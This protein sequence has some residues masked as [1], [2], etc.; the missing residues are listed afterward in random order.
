M[1]FICCSTCSNN[2]KQCSGLQDSHEPTYRQSLPAEFKNILFQVKY[3]CPYCILSKCGFDLPK[4]NLDGKQFFESESQMDEADDLYLIEVQSLIE[5]IGDDDQTL[6]S[7]DA[8]F[9]TPPELRR[10][11]MLEC[12]SFMK[13][14]GKCLMRRLNLKI[15]QRRPRSKSKI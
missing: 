2:Q 12:K 5:V 4:H 14:Y 1:I 6:F 3:Q 15:E 11:L 13:I 8:I 10:H 9:F 7:H